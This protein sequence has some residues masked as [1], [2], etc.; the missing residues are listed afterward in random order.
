MDLKIKIT[1]IISIDT[2]E[3]FDK[4]LHDFTIKILERI[5]LEVTDF[6]II[7]AIYNKPTITIIVNGENLK[8]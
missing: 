5:G 4:I 3:V 6:N 7:K 8:H 2:E 1:W